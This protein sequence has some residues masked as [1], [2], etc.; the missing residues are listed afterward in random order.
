M[1]ETGWCRLVPALLRDVQE[2]GNRE[3]VVVAMETLLPAC[4]QDFAH[5]VPTLK[6]LR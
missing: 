1:V 4:R 3:Q 2:H 6:K 5:S